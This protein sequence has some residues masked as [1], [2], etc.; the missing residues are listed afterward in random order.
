VETQSFS[1]VGTVQEFF[2]GGVFLRFELGDF[3]IEV[4]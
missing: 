3:A 1:R 2:I 4:R